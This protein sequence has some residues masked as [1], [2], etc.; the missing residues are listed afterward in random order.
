MVLAII[1]LTDNSDNNQSKV[2]GTGEFPLDPGIV[3]SGLPNIELQTVTINVTLF[4]YQ[5]IY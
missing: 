5:V 4:L 1:W 3:R 2:E